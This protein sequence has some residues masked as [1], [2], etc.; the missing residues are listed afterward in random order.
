MN[1]TYTSPWIGSSGTFSIQDLT[2]DW[3]PESFDPFVKK[4]QVIEI[5]EDLL[6][7][8]CAWQRIR[9]NR[10]DANPYVTI[11]SLTDSVLFK[12]LTQED[13]DKA[14][15]VRDYYSKKIMLWKLKGDTLSQF[16]EDM[17]AFIHTE[18]KVFK[19]DKM[20][21]VYRL[22]EFYDYDSDIDMLSN[23]YNKKVSQESPNEITGK[24]LKLIKTFIVNK[25]HAK[26]KEYWFSDDTNNLVSI[27]IECSNPLISLLDMHTQNSIK[28]N[29]IYTKRSRDNSEYLIA[30]KFKF[31]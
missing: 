16:R 12:E 21:L 22:P 30:N 1:H 4:Y 13:R 9:M 25:K 7:L 8:S 19:E 15:Q 14:M 31:V 20:P 26:R 2:S 5:E 28:V 11:S 17:N 27:S 3:K 10:K 29:A 23:D 18:G 24:R 6:A